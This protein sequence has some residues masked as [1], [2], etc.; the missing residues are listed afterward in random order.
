[1]TQQQ[2]EK[3]TI[4]IHPKAKNQNQCLLFESGTQK[5]KEKL[6]VSKIVLFTSV[7]V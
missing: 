4:H 1:M 2:K 6:R 3:E 7:S 5:L